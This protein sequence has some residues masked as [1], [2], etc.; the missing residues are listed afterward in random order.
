MVERERQR[1][2]GSVFNIMRESVCALTRE[3]KR[4]KIC[5]EDREREEDWGQFK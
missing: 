2:R 3:R 5:L 4:K 1:E